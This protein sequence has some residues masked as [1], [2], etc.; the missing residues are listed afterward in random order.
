MPPS[1]SPERKLNLKTLFD[2][3]PLPCRQLCLFKVLSD[4]DVPWTWWTY[5]TSFHSQCSME[6]NRFTPECAY[7]IMDGL[8]A[9]VAAVKECEGNSDLDQPIPLLEVSHSINKLISYG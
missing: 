4:A 5:V 7:G 6:D 8:G 9:D 3:S 2:P 1:F